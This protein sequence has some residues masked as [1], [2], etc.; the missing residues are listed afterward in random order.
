MPKGL[1]SRWSR[2]LVVVV[3]YA[4][5]YGLVR[6]LSFSHWAPFA[7][8]RFS[9]LL[10]VPYRYWPALLVGEAASLAYA[11]IDC[12]E[13]FGWLWASFFMIPPMIFSMPLLR[14][15]RGA[16]RIFATQNRANISVLLLATLCASLIWAAVNTG[17]LILMRTRPGE[18]ID[19]QAT[20]ARYFIGNYIGVLTLVPL[21]LLVREDLLR[22]GM[23]QFLKRLPESRL[24]MET[25]C[26]LFPSLAL[27]VWL[28]SGAAGPATEEARMAM[29]LPVAWLSLRHG[30]RG[31]AVGGCAA[32]I[33]VVLAMPFHR[34]NE[35]L[36]AQVFVAF[37]VTTMLMLAARIAAL[38]E[39]EERERADA[40]HALAVAQRNVYLGELQLQQ[41]SHALEQVS[42]AVQASYTQLLGRLQ[43][44]LPGTDERN[45]YRQAAITQHR[46][47]RLADS[48][49]PLTWGE[50]GLPAALREGS[51]PRALDEAGIVY[52]CRLR[53]IE[54]REL[55]TGI[56]IALYRL[57]VEA[58]A[59]VCASR[60][61]SH[62]HV[63]LRSGVFA[64]RRWVVLRVDSR[65]DLAQLGRVRWDEIFSVLGGSGLG[66]G[67][68][69]DRAMVFGGKV[70]LRTMANGKRLT[71][72]L[73]E[74]GIS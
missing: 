62:V 9:V 4:V 36:H 29:F 55:S 5:A 73:F 10:L 38:R 35:T 28:A 64:G 22:F 66:L 39:G 49:Y 30:W 74:P 43:C 68:I 45:Y 54:L 42:S 47:Y 27:L 65:V 41:T 56:H 40:R 59:L 1:G 21:V 8:L 48:L 52:W 72:M 24:A 12:A 19:Y 31:A 6:Q 32:S 33:A 25:V 20:A 37:T 14:W 23:R 16:G 50:R 26:L 63:Q 70:R 11:G 3:A 61:I 71:V 44:L 18:I 57:T 34:D 58:L 60:D 67:A 2:H 17:T 69:K 53:E 51:I 13:R 7:G 15:C 46:I